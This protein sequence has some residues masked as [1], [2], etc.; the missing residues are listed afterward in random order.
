[1]NGENKTQW[2]LGARVWAEYRIGH[3]PELY[4][5]MGAEYGIFYFRRRKDGAQIGKTIHQIT[6]YPGFR[7]FLINCEYFDP[8]QLVKEKPNAIA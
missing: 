2:F 8:L 5:F 6:N 7:P 4:D 1:M 3:K